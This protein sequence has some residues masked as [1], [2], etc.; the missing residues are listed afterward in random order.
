MIFNCT[1]NMEKIISNKQEQLILQFIYYFDNNNIKYQI[2]G[3]LA[4]NLYGSLWHLHDIDFETSLSNL[5]II[6]NDFADYVTL[7]TSRYIDN[8]FNIWLLRLEINGI[9]IDIN[10]VEDFYLNENIKIETNLENAIDKVFIGEKVKVQPLKDIINYK[11]ILNRQN[12]LKDLLK[13]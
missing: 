8:E 5:A 4:G 9:E 1:N 7:K 3:G 6:E 10:A 13:L 11:K 2:T 12:D